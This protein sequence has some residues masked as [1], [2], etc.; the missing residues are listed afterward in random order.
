MTDLEIGK[1]VREI[2]LRDSTAEVK[3]N[4]NREVIISEIKKKIIKS[5]KTHQNQTTQ[6]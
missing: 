6:L 3:Q 2:L 4:K 5:D 1:A